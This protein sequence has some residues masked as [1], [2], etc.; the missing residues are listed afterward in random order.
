MEQKYG[1]WARSRPL[2][3]AVLAEL[4]A[5]EGLSPPTEA[6]DPEGPWEHVYRIWAVAAAPARCHLGYLRIRRQPD[7]RASSVTLTVEKR[8]YLMGGD[9]Y[10][11]N[12]EIKCADDLL[13][14]PRSWRIESVI[15]GTDGKP[16]EATRVKERV[17]LKNDK[18][19]V[20]A[21]GRTMARDAGSPL[22]TDW[23][24]FDVVQRLPGEKT[25]ALEFAMLEELDMLKQ[26]Q[27]LTYRGTGE[28]ALN[29]HTLRL[30]CYE[31][32]GRG[33]LPYAYWVD[34]RRRLMM[35]ISHTRTYICDPDAPAR[36]EETRRELA[37]RGKR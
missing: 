20:N 22:T 12:A 28:L 16:V 23:G 33:I 21:G 18:L 24:L 19:R 1:D 14:T 11:T 26:G 17:N 25:E 27:R 7:R 6:F 4:G 2:S 37:E 9:A 30:A 36:V 8:L 34:Q 3:P 31:V 10:Q 5:L 13:G 29:G 35:A 32:L 15:I